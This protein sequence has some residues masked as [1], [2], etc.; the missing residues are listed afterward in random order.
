M[1]PF[2]TPGNRTGIGVHAQ[3]LLHSGAGLVRHAEVVFDVDAAQDQHFDVLLHFP[4]N[5]RNQ[6]IGSHDY[7]ARCQRA[8]KGAGE[9]A[10]GSRNHIIDRGCVGLHL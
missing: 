2:D 6:I 8:G 1:N 9:S 7:L 3:Y 5:V 10:A 4:C